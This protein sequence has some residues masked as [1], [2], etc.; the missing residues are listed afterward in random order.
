M[1]TTI[2]STASST[3]VP[4]TTSTPAKAPPVDTRTM[5]PEK[6]ES[7]QAVQ[8][9]GRSSKP[10]LQQAAPNSAL[11]TYK[12]QDSGRLIV[13]VYD[14][15]NGDILVE[16]PPEKAFR[17]VEEVLQGVGKKPNKTISV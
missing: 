3:A 8:A 11:T 17:S 16:F 9:S 15:Q 2:K 13:R 12:D 4:N 7:P 10:V 14:R 1:D 5:T 6:V